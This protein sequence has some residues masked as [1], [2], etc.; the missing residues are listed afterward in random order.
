MK[1]YMFMQYLVLN[2][3]VDSLQHPLTGELIGQVGL[4]LITQTQN[5]QQV[6]EVSGCSAW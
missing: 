1:R 6:K 2:E 5:T 3:G 4:N